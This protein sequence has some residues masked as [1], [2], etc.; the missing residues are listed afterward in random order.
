MCRVYPRIAGK[1]R[2]INPSVLS[3][4]IAFCFLLLLYEP[5]STTF[6]GPVLW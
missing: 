6:A 5:R 3:G 4:F 2:F 1:F